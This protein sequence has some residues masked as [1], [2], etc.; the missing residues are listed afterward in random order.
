MTPIEIIDE[1]VK[2]YAQDS[3]GRRAVHRGSCMYLTPDNRSCALGRLLTDETKT[4]LVASGRNGA[5]VKN[6]FNS[7]SLASFKEQYRDA[8]RELMDKGD[9]IDFLMGLQDL[10]DSA[11]F[12]ISEE[13]REQFVGDL[14]QNLAV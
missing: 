5:G 12:W 4:E 8:I 9:C 13:L 14:K 11:S 3:E 6:I 10:H 1:T 2:F 7:L